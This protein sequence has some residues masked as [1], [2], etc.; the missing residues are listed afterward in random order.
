[1]ALS[2]LDSFRREVINQMQE[3]AREAKVELLPIDIAVSVRGEL[4]VANAVIAPPYGTRIEYADKLFLLYVSLPEEHEMAKKLP[5]GCYVVERV[6]HSPPS[7]ARL[8]NLKGEVVLEVPLNQVRTELPP[9]AYQWTSGEPPVVHSQAHIE[10]AYATLYRDVII[11]GHGVICYP[12][13]W[14]WT[15]IIIV[16]VELPFRY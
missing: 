9:E 5:K 6:R 3:A 1:M 2:Q 8:V 7:R 14:Y 4:V 15:W 12:G 11:E 13:V 10:Q 16:I